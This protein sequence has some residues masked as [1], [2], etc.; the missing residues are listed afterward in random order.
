MGFKIESMVLLSTR[1]WYSFL[2]ILI[3]RWLFKGITFIYFLG[4]LLEYC[5]PW[6]EPTWWPSFKGSY[7][8]LESVWNELT[9]PSKTIFFP[10]SWFIANETPISGPVFYDA[11]L[12]GHN[13]R[14]PGVLGFWPWS[15]CSYRT[16]NLVN[17]CFWSCGLATVKSNSGRLVDWVLK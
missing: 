9:K 6:E 13:S 16:T 11:T 10:V 8:T 15:C 7:G 14:D 12:G 2:L 4:N 3:S 17:F 1:I 5:Q